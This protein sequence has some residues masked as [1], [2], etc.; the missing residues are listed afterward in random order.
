MKGMMAGVVAMLA[1]VLPAHAFD[2][3]DW[4]HWTTEAL[5][6]K[7]TDRWNAKVE[8]EFY[9]GDD[10]SDLFY[11]HTDIGFSRKTAPWFG[12]GVNYRFVEQEK[13]GE[14]KQEHRPHINGTFYMTAGGLRLS[15][16]NRVEY[17]EREDASDFWRYRNRL[18]IGLPLEWAQW[19]IEPY[20]SDE[21]FMDSEQEQVN[22][23]RISA[24]LASG[25]LKHFKLELYYMIQSC[26]KNAAW[27]DTN[28]LGT[29]LSFSF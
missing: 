29:S 24:G 10:M 26:K 11:R 4:Q 9:W 8:T 12:V 27:V 28:V 16:R 2:N 20:V 17:R 3:Q 6:Y 23:N 19:N 1:S 22:E 13:N 21:V 7:V 15:D 5:E 18:R 14:W 25:F